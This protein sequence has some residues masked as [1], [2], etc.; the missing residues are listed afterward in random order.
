MIVT[1][2]AAMIVGMALWGYGLFITGH[3]PLID[4]TSNTP[5]WIADYLPNMESELGLVLV[6]LGSLAP[7]ITGRA[8]RGRQRHRNATGKLDDDLPFHQVAVAWRDAMLCPPDRID[9]RAVAA[10]AP[11]AR[12][13]DARVVVL[14]PQGE[15]DAEAAASNSVD[16]TERRIARYEQV[17]RELEQ[18]IQ[19]AQVRDVPL[20]PVTCLPISFTAAAPSTRRGP[21]P[22]RCRARA[23]SE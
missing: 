23:T 12:Q 7:Y 21:S 15:P 6:C 3:P 4:W 20:T 2:W 9:V 18:P 1:L 19:I 17:A 11:L 8:G 5:W 16:S 10:A 22:L 14:I 13:Q